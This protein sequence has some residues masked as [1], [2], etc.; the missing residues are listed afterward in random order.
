M[1]EIAFLESD[2]LPL[3]ALQHLVFCPRQCALI[4]LEQAWE[5]NALTAEGRILHEKTDSA[6][7][8]W[9]GEVRIAR[10]L[11][12]R[13]L[14]LGLAGVADVVEFHPVEGDRSAPASAGDFDA[15]GVKLPGIRGKWR[16]FPVEYKRGRP[17]KDD[18]DRVQLCAQALCLEEMLGVAVP[19]GALFYGET[20]RRMDVVFDGR[21][22][23]RTE[24]VAG[25]L[26]ALMAAGVTPA[27]IY[28]PKCRRCSLVEI[29]MPQMSERKE[30]VD[31]FVARAV[32]ATV[33]AGSG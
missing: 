9:R 22:R 20:R 6:K 2:L 33:E 31:G 8:E 7:A 17:K 28:E 5:E 1:G 15:L 16:P 10:S 13:S 29:C 12:I 14:R 30:S 21:L 4:H 23:T 3:S 19:N 24:A 18:A 11:R 25:E 26:H 27:A 32:R